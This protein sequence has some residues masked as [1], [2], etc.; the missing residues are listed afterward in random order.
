[1]SLESQWVVDNPKVNQALAT[2]KEKNAN[3]TVAIRVNSY[4]V[5]YVTPEQAQ[6]EKF[7]E[8]MIY[9][10]NHPDILFID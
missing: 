4:T 2:A 10:Y 3:K 7:I 6:D 8:R 9:K 1:M 5:V